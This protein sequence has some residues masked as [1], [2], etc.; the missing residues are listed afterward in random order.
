MTMPEAK[1]TVAYAGLGASARAALMWGAGFTLIRDVLQFAT[2]L[3]LVRL[4]SPADYGSMAFAQAVIS[5]LS[6]M[7]FGTFASH[8]LQSRDPQQVD[9]QSHFTAAA[10]LNSALFVLALGL[11]FCLSLTERF[12]AA[13]L[14]LAVLSLVFILEI[15]AG[16]R[17]F[18]A[19]VEH[20]WRTFRSQLLVGAL[21]GCSA[22]VVIALM[23][24]GI[25]ALIVQPIL[26]PLPAAAD[27]ILVR[28]WRPAWTWSR[29]NYLQSAKFG[30]TRVASA[31]INGSR[32]LAEQA[33][34][35]AVFDFTA[36]GI[37]T[38]ALGLASLLAGRIGTVATS[39]LYPVITRA[40]SGSEQFRHF[41]QLVLQGVAWLTIPAAALL[42]IAAN[43]I[44]ALLYGAKWADVTGL[45]PLASAT[46]AITGI[47]AAAYYLLLA[48]DQPRT[49]L[50]I[51]VVSGALGM[52]LILLVLPRGAEIYL[53]SLSAH[54]CAILTVVL[55]ALAASGGL[56]WRSAA[57]ALLPSL[58]AALV[59]LLA[60]SA[61]RHLHGEAIWPPL[62]LALDTLLFAASY[63]A[64][65]RA[66]FAG[67]T[68]ALLIASPG[69]ARIRRY[70]F[71]ASPR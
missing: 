24:G 61:G 7:A 30:A 38:R 52:A 3:V 15:P 8:I 65:L 71:P 40:Q 25:W 19:Q 13:A 6:V 18:M 34:L 68:E 5:L 63:L 43:D 44:V 4:L 23:G 36:L 47:T 56:T 20:D 37:F 55:A 14:P 22:G 9:W 46:I 2:M 54:G 50:A 51:D 21:L 28:R 67:Q 11:A 27:L 64:V 41:A 17:T 53:L 49:C 33:T 35:A 60:T 66:C 69:G 10:V 12:A 31:A 58:V 42:S 59:A 70:L 1:P 48:N 62:R 29:T 45:V 26:A 16:L 39:A 32:Q 57:A